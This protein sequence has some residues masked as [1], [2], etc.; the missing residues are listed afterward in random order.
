MTQ[1]EIGERA[2]LLRVVFGHYHAGGYTDALAFVEEHASL[3]DEGERDWF[4]TCLRARIGDVAGAIAAFRAEIDRGGWFDEASLQDPDL[5]PLRVDPEFQRL[6]A[7]SPIRKREAQA[8]AC[9]TFRVVTPDSP[10]PREGYPVVVALHGNSANAELTAKDWSAAAAD[11][12]LVAAIQSSQVGRRRG[13]FVW[14]DSHLGTLEIQE[15]FASVERTHP[16][17][18]TRTVLGGFSLGAFQAALV[19]LQGSISARA[20][21]LVAPGIP[22]LEP[23]IDAARSR[24]DRDV[25]GYVILGDADASQAVDKGRSLVGLLNGLGYQCELDA[26]SGM[27][28]EY[29]SDFPETLRRALRLV[30]SH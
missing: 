16:V 24:R 7:L 20:F 5:D 23:L 28:H 27:R 11:G 1:P 13:A 14:N 21:I 29:P 9:P 15:Q 8:N 6:A 3:L 26:R 18:R 17:A 19:A 2:D 4:R 12:W 30:L 22:S 25:R 10:P